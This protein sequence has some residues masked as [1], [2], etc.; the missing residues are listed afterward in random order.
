MNGHRDYRRTAQ[1]RRDGRRTGRVCIAV[2]AS[3]E[4]RAATVIDNKPAR[5]VVIFPAT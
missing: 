2:S 3:G 1:V 4:S 5:V